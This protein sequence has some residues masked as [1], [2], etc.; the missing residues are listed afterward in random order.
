[1]D[2]QYEVPVVIELDATSEVTLGKYAEDS[3]DQGRYFE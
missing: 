1:M 2:G 3:K